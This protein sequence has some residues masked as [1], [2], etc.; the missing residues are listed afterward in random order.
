MGLF[1]AIC[2]CCCCSMPREDFG[3]VC[4]RRLGEVEKMLGLT[5]PE[6]VPPLGSMSRES[7]DGVC[8][9]DSL[10]GACRSVSLVEIW[11]NGSK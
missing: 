2:S 6:V 4:L 1:L 10:K 8:R 7:N 5:F 3:E 9:S 11:S